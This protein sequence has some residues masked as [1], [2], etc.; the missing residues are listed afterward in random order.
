MKKSRGRRRGSYALTH[1]AQGPLL[2]E[3]VAAD[4]LEEDHLWSLGLD[5]SEREPEVRVCLQLN[6]KCMLTP[7]IGTGTKET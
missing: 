4:A 2:D 5:E 1:T 3:S 7:R 6:P